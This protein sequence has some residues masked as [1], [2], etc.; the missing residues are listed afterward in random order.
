MK[1]Y[2]MDPYQ[3]RIF[4]FGGRALLA[5]FQQVRVVLAGKHQQQ[6]VADQVEHLRQR[7]IGVNGQLQVI[8][9]TCQ[10]VLNLGSVFSNSSAAIS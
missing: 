8:D 1:V 4:L 7:D 3:G 10:Y 9:D 2:W 6:V 5:F